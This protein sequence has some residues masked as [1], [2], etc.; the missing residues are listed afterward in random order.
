MHQLLAQKQGPYAALLAAA[1]LQPAELDS[2]V[3]MVPE[4]RYIEVSAA[5]FLPKCNAGDHT[6]AAPIIFHTTGRGLRSSEQQIECGGGS[7]DERAAYSTALRSHFQKCKAEGLML[8]YGGGAS[9]T[10]LFRIAAAQL[11][12]GRADMPWVQHQWTVPAADLGGM[13]ERAAHL[14][15]KKQ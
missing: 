4:G 5:S 8:A 15:R 11:P 14:F 2:L 13:T 10:I 6:T 3:Q 1:A 7:T 9:T 12:Q